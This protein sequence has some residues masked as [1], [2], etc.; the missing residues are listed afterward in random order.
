MRSTRIKYMGSAVALAGML[1]LAGA[2]SAFADSSIGTTG[3]GSTN[4]VT[5]NNSTSYTSDTTNSVSVSNVNFQSGSSGSANVSGNTTGGSAISGDVTNTNTVQTTIAIGNNGATAGS[6]SAGSGSGT[7]SG[8]GAGSGS[9]SSVSATSAS[10]TPGKGGGSVSGEGTT[11]SGSAVLP[12]TGCSQACTAVANALRGSYK[13][14]GITASAIK[15]AKGISAGLLGLAA[16][17][18]LAGGVGSAFYASKR[19]KA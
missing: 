4:T 15:Q 9:G 18:S 8:A 1:T 5:N 2:G 14:A 7:G 19:A 10:S 11:G 6:G 13:P 3:P 12:A 16:A 17:L